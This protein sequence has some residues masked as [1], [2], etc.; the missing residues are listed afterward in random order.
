MR[1]TIFRLCRR[2]AVFLFALLALSA[3]TFFLSRLAPGDPLKSFYG[4]SVE[5]MSLSEQVAAR[6]RLGLDAPLPVQYGRWL[7]AALHGEFG[8]SL[9]YKQP[10]A[11]VIAGF[12][13]NTLLLGGLSYLLTFALAVPLGVFCC[14]REDSLAD[15]IICKVGTITGCIPS[16]WIALVLI[17][18]FSVNLRLLPSSGAYAMGQSDDLFSRLRH[19]VLPLVVMVLGHLWYYAYLV[20]NKLLDEA[21]KSYVL[22]CKARGL[23]NRRI[24]WAHCLRGI[25]PSLF[26]I[27]AVSVPHILGGTYVV[28]KVFSYPGLGTLCFESAKY[29][30]YNLLMLLS[31]MTGAV[32]IASGMLAQAL[33][34]RIDARMVREGDA[35]A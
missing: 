22:L 11:P 34:E 26:S 27:M 9:K 1:R 12:L 4:E 13:P 30:D 2:L 5:R 24:V 19:L 18:I 23:T 32:V 15:R 7:S 14:L 21:R 10:A 16:F 28:E 20:R 33:S 17:L 35:D 3:F 31:L 6:T 8:I 29:H 25:L